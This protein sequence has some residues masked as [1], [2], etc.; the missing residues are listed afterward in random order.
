[1]LAAELV[2]QRLAGVVWTAG[3][4]DVI[5]AERF[6]VPIERERRRV[7]PVGDAPGLHLVVGRRVGVG[8]LRQPLSLGIGHPLTPPSC[9]SPARRGRPGRTR[10]PAARPERC[11]P[12]TRPPTDAAG[13]GQRPAPPSPHRPSSATRSL[14]RLPEVPGTPGSPPCSRARP[15]PRP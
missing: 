5:E 7:G 9:A 14:P 2:V 13:S 3:G 10:R 6:V 12:R 4:A 1:H 15:P 8:G 11:P